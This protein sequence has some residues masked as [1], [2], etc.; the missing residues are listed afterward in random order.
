[1]MIITPIDLIIALSKR[2]EAVVKDYRFP[3]S[4]GKHK[5]RVPRV[6]T[7]YLPEKKFDNE[8]DLADPPFV[9]VALGGGVV[10]EGGHG[11]CPIGILIAGYDGGIIVEE[12]G[13]ESRSRQGW[14][15]PAEM[16]WR[17]IN[18]LA[19]QPTMGPFKLQYPIT[20]ELPEQES[21]SEH[22]FG[23]INTTWE[24]PVTE[25]NYNL[26]NMKFEPLTRDER[27]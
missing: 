8:V 7:Q 18:A 13:L 2:L 12:E 24:V 10:S 16:T 17:I 1:M 21:P 27:M 23:L 19:K 15:I 20:W 25:P 14:M 5:W 22:W 4:D 6:W 3:E 26:R 11:T 9:L